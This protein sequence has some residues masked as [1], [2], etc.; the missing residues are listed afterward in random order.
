[1]ALDNRIATRHVFESRMQILI[2]RGANNL[3]VQG[4]ARDLSESGVGAFVAE[5]LEIGEIVT[6]QIQIVD[7]DK[8]MIAAQV[9][10]RLGTQYGFQFTA[11]SAEQRVTILDLLKGNVIQTNEPTRK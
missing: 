8:V 10:R 4:W 1:M 3:V 6:L 5:N 9:A 7:A 2:R 11:L